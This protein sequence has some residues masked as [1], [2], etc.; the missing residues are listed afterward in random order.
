MAMTSTVEL[1]GLRLPV[2]LGTYGPGDVV[3][4]AHFLDMSLTID[5]SLVLVDGDSMA[6]VFD[7]DPLIR[8]IECL[9]SDGHYKTQEWLMSKIAM[10]CAKYAAIE[11]VELKVYKTPVLDGTGTLGVQLS[12]DQNGL[13]RLRAIVG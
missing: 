8:E 13:S 4:D 9:A 3:P 1:T 5:A 2:D 12:I 6:K 11:A 10:A 7:Y